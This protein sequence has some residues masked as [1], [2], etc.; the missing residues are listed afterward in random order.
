VET[1]QRV[2]TRGSLVY[3]LGRAKGVPR[4]VRVTLP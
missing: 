1:I 2:R 3:V 4:L